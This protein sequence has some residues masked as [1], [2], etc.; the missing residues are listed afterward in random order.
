MLTACFCWPA[1]DGGGGDCGGGDSGGGTACHDVR[2]VPFLYLCMC[3][4]AHVLP[5]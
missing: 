1:G 5:G 3:V 2:D 4:H